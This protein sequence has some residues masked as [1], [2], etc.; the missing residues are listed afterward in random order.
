[1]EAITPDPNAINLASKSCPG[2]R[3]E[4]VIGEAQDAAS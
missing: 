3:Y 1:M 4:S 2:A